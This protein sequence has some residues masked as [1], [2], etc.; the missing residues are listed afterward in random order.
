MSSA[1]VTDTIMAEVPAPPSISEA[2][3]QYQLAMSQQ[4][5][6]QPSS[7]TDPNSSA[8]ELGGDSIVNGNAPEVSGVCQLK[9]FE[10]SIANILI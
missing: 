10:Y 6:P 2:A 3:H 4:V 8:M 1:E 9:S 5:A 7:S